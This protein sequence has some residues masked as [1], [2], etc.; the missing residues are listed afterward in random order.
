[1]G[2]SFNPQTVSSGFRDVDL[3]NQILSDI[4]DDL[5]NKIDRNGV[6]P[7]AMAADLDLGSNRLLNVAQGIN[8]TDGVNLN[9]LTNVATS[10]ATTIAASGGESGTTTGDPITINYGVADGSQGTSNRTVFDLNTLFGVSSLNG[11]TVVV[12]GVV[13]IPG[14]SYTL[15]GTVVTF[16]SSLDANTEILF[17][18]GELSPTPTTSL[19]V[20][21]Y[22]I[23]VHI[24]GIPSSNQEVLR[25]VAVRDILFQDNFANSQAT[26]NI[27]AT[28]ETTFTIKVD[29][30]S[31]GTIVFAAS[32]TSGTFSTSGGELLVSTGE[33]LSIEN[34]ATPDATLS[35][36]SFTLFGTRAS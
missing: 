7:N 13:Q 11:L 10:I 26:A 36:I 18:Y 8:G 1:M 29:G 5:E 22:D 16:V 32:G 20:N 15:N 34:Q 9:Q 25:L 19:T 28:A 23:A 21:N 12:N 6:A 2:T 14:R 35:D 33:V 17:I 30:V 3:I 24:D 31:V 27:A 4:R